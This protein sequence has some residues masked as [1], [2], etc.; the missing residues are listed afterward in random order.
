MSQPD[1]DINH[2]EVAAHS[3]AVN[4]AAEMLFE[5]LS[6]AQYVDL[7]DEAYG[8]LCSPLFL[9]ELNPMQYDAVQEI[10]RM[11]KA[12]QHISDLLKSMADNLK[13]T[14]EAAAQRFRQEGGN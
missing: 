2:A 12:T 13:L 11:A 9:P 7:H 10:Q 8:I 4:E 1:I 3:R 5:A 14:D 6:G